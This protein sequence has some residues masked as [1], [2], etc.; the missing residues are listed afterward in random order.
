MHKKEY[1]LKITSPK[2]KPVKVKD[3]NAPK[4]NL[5][6][7]FL[8]TNEERAK[9]KEANPDFGVTDV[10]KELGRRWSEMDAIAKSKYE[11]MAEADKL[12]Y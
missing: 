4:R 11:K 9:V 8:F 5:T 12:R 6:P 1:F 2:K 7:Y 10:A 3:P